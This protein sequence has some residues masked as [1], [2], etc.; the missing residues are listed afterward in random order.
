MKQNILNYSKQEV[1]NHFVENNIEKG[2]RAAQ[3]FSWL[4]DRGI[5]SFDM[6]HNVPIILRKYLIENFDITIP[7]CRKESISTDGTIKWQL[8]TE[9]NDPK[10]DIETVYIPEMERNTLCISSQVGCPIR[11]TFCHTGTQKFAKNLTAGEIIGQLLFAYKRLQVL[12]T[13]AGNISN[14][15]FMGMGEPLL[16]YNNV[17]KAIKTITTAKIFNITSKKITVST[18]GVV[19]QIKALGNDTKVKLAI[20]LHAVKDEIRNHLVPL[21]KKYPIPVLLEA[22][23]EYHQITKE[24]ITFEYVM[25]KD[26]NDSDD[27][28]YT[29]IKA[30]QNVNCKINLIPFNRWEGS[31]YCSSTNEQILRFQQIL[32]NA[33]YATTVRKNRGQDIMAACGQ[34]K[35]NCNTI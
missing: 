5:T 1:A 7:I 27:D 20:S 26:I 25:L 30:V 13:E 15:V 21:N 12:R 35:S 31:R 32:K 6:M 16:N 3:I 23:E 9:E 2:F 8:S 18:S 4:Y 28:A 24:K 29:M 14:V 19:P 17:V 10:L 11:C 22:C 34:L 33:G